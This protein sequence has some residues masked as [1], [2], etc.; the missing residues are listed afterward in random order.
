M[1]VYLAAP[2]F[3]EGEREFNEKIKSRLTREGFSVFLPQVEC[4]EDIFDCCIENLKKSDVVVGVFDGAQVDDGTAFECGYANSLG[5]PIVALRT[6]FRRVGEYT[7]AVNAMLEG[8]AT[9]CKNLDDVVKV[10]KEIRGD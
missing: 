4:N 7:N 8:S 6:D 5:V 9:M 1:R 2:L 3:S 10:L